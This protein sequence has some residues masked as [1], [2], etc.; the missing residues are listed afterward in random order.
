MYAI[1]A[2]WIVAATILP[3][4][5]LLAFRMARRSA[6][7]VGLRGSALSFKPLFEAA[8]RKLSVIIPVRNDQ[9]KLLQTLE[10][11]LRYL[12]SREQQQV[13]F[14]W[15]VLVV[16]AGPS[17]SPRSCYQHFVSKFSSD[18]VR[19]I[20]LPQRLGQGA[21]VR[22]GMLEARGELLLMA[23]AEGSTPIADVECLEGQLQMHITR[24]QAHLQ[25][26]RPPNSPGTRLGVPP[27]LGVVVGTSG[28]VSRGKA[29]WLQ[30]AMRF[31][32]WRSLFLEE[33]APGRTDFRREQEAYNHA[34]QTAGGAALMAGHDH[35]SYMAGYDAAERL[36][37]FSNAPRMGQR[38][39]AVRSPALPVA[40][41]CT[42]GCRF[43]LY[44]RA[45][46]RILFPKQ[47]VMGAS[48]EVELLY[49]ASRLS[50]P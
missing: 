8:S 10:E 50:V 49:L 31:G 38:A 42:S 44:T 20:C 45:A 21:S 32:L 7:D 19:I 3:L 47:H 17:D 24:P 41:P 36:G 25:L 9:A 23:N 39:P 35:S 46:A 18:K 11:I 22:E 5:L 28:P 48:F 1:E 34:A 33:Y 26:R 27:D 37:G 15:E 2:T 30:K 6:A 13:G 4:A 14:T 12:S 16:D 29:T 40:S 43:T